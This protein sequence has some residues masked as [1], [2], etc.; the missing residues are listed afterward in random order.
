MKTTSSK[1]S[2]L[3]QDRPLPE[4][5]LPNR[6]FATLNLRG[7]DQTDHVD[8]AMRAFLVLSLLCSMLVCGW[9]GAVPATGATAQINA[10]SVGVEAAPQPAAQCV[11][12]KVQTTVYRL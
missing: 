8:A 1:S 4:T 3:F 7:L 5:V 9:Q 2:R 6:R 10:P 11:A 12:Q